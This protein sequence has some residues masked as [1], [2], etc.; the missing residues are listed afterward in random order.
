[1]TSLSTDAFA[2]LS[3]LEAQAINGGVDPN[4]STIYTGDLNY[5]QAKVANPGFANPSAAYPYGVGGLNYGQYK[6]AL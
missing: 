3:D 4:P 1:M 5:G 2:A 6:K